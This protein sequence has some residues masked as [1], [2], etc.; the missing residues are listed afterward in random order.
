MSLD[1]FEAIRLVD[2]AGMYQDAGSAQMDISRQTLGRIL[3]RA[4]RK[5]VDV[6]VQGKALRIEGGNVDVQLK[7]QPRC[8]KCRY[9]LS[10]MPSAIIEGRCHHFRR[11]ALGSPEKF[12]KE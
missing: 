1:E 3:E 6:L 5:I 10:R 11:T 9:S 7:I 2:L 12:S 4:H 8:P